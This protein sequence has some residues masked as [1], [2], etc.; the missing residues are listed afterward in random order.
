[1]ITVVGLGLPA[2]EGLGYFSLP[3]L[4]LQVFVRGRPLRLSGPISKVVTLVFKGVV[5]SLN[6]RVPGMGLG[7]SAQKLPTRSGVH[8]ERG[9]QVSTMRG[10][11][12]LR[13]DG[14]GPV[15]KYLGHDSSGMMLCGCHDV[16]ECRQLTARG[17]IK[18]RAKFGRNG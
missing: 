2:G 3:S 11:R 4:R 10:D 8:R 1:M 14:E 18:N 15:E 5:K 17:H 13:K 7:L 9:T 12:A 16:Q 6:D